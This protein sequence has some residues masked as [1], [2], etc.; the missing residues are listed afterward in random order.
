MLELCAGAGQIGLVLAHETGCLLVQVDSDERAC[1]FARHNAHANDLEAD[2]RCA[3]LEDA[4]AP[5]ERFRLV[6]ADPPYIRSGDTGQ[7]RDDPA[8][9]I[10]GGD[11]GLD[12][13]RACL[14]VT[15]R[16]L[17]DGGHVL[18]QLGGPEQAATLSTEAETFGLEAIETRVHGI[19]RSLLL[20]RRAG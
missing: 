17:L 13:A 4:L 6:L 19:D 12:L 15:A 16:H 1:H 2:L 10:D 14:T 3:S 8:H 11:D 9:A 20:L 5:D 7:Y 18:I